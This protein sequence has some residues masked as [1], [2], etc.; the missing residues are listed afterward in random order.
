MPAIVSRWQGLRVLKVE[1]DSQML[2]AVSDADHLALAALR[3]DVLDVQVTPKLPEELLAQCKAVQLS[4]LG[5][6]TIK[7]L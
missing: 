3:G 7:W 5:R 4:V 1:V 2:Q 6:Y